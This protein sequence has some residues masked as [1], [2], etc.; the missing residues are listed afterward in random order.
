MPWAL[1]NYRH[2][3]SATVVINEA[4]EEKYNKINRNERSEAISQPNTSSE[5][6]V[7][8]EGGEQIKERREKREEKKCSQTRFTAFLRCDRRAGLLTKGSGPKRET[9][10]SKVKQLV[11]AA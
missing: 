8:E 11:A 7:V 9:E 4:S 3:G 1:R 10:E 5:A 6:L 2:Q